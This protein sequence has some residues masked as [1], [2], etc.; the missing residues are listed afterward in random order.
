MD[1]QNTDY[2]DIDGNTDETETT[3]IP[4][5]AIPY[6][7]LARKIATNLKKASNHTKFLNECIIK[8]TVP[9]GLQGKVTPQIPENDWEFIL[10]WE[11]TQL[12]CAKKLRLLLKDYYQSRQQT[13][14]KDF[15]DAKTK[16]ENKCAPE[17]YKLALD[18][19]T[20]IEETVDK[21]QKTKKTKKT[22]TQNTTQNT[23]INTPSAK[24]DRP[25]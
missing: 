19:I 18:L 23:T 3:R 11:Q 13:L 8:N 14:Q 9:K 20:K 4:A 7:K 17:E 2:D 16:L 10:K 5:D 6:Y 12:D 21:Q 24:D 15:E 22:P 25:N 1:Q